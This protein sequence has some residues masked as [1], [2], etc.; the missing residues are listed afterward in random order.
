MR[1]QSRKFS[2]IALAGAAMLGAILVDFP[3]AWADS[4]GAI[5]YVPQDNSYEIRGGDLYLL[6]GSPLYPGWGL[7]QPNTLMNIAQVSATDGA[8]WAIN[9]LI[10]A[11]TQYAN[12]GNGLG[13]L[14]IYSGEAQS[15]ARALGGNP[16]FA[17]SRAEQYQYSLF[18]RNTFNTTQ[19]LP[20]AYLVDESGAIFTSDSSTLTPIG[21]YYD[22]TTGQTYTRYSSTF[23]IAT[24]R[25]PV[26]QSLSA[27]VQGN[28]VTLNF[29]TAV[30]L[31]S[32]LATYHYDAV[33]LTN[34]TTGQTQWLAGTGSSDMS[35]MQAE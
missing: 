29:N 11:D 22:P 33:Q 21:T 13:Y 16:N 34:T 9:D 15:V 8:G 31:Y 2:R 25:W 26:A 35:Q 12:V 1:L 30:Y 6:Q 14:G 4:F 27:S 18:D 10:Q 28:S 3:N 7:I 32:Q 17:V 19:L 5:V 23:H 20:F 24:S